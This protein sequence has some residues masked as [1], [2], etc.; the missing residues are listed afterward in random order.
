MYVSAS[1]SLIN[2]HVKRITFINRNELSFERERKEKNIKYD[3]NAVC[4]L[5]LRK[6]SIPVRQ[7]RQEKSF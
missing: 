2:I 1:Y 7:E 5:K 6:E 3:V 4:E